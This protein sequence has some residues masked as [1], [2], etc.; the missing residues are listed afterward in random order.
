MPKRTLSSIS[1]SRLFVAA[2]L[3]L[4]VANVVPHPALGPSLTR[5]VI[6]GVIQPVTAAEAVR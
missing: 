2:A 6:D 4:L 5:Q 3:T 1:L